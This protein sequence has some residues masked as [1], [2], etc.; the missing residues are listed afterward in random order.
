MFLF[1]LDGE[2]RGVLLCNNSLILC[3]YVLCTFP[4]MC[5]IPMKTL[6]KTFVIGNHSATV[7]RMFVSSQH[8][9]VETESPV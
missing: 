7:E 2:Y 8:S 9:Y 6:F 5:P 1:G 3:L 4:F